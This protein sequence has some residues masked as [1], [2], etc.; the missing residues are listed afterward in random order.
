MLPKGDENCTGLG[1]LSF[2]KWMTV[3]FLIYPA[4]LPGL[5][6]YTIDSIIKRVL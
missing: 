6:F 3:S 1:L 5:L 4:A 2:S